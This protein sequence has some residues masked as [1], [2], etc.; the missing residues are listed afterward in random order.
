MPSTHWSNMENTLNTLVKSFAA[1][2]GEDYVDDLLNR[3]YN[4]T[5]VSDG[6]AVKLAWVL[7]QPASCAMLETGRFYSRLSGSAG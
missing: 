2:W 4:P 3:G 1:V 7:T 6:S 5:L